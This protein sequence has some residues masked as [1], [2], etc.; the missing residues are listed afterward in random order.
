M[1]DLI[2]QAKTEYYKNRLKL[3]TAKDTFRFVRDLTQMR[4]SCLSSVDSDTAP[5]KKFATFFK[6]KVN[7]IR[8]SLDQAASASNL[9]VDDLLSQPNRTVS[10]W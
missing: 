3:T 10:V 2:K 7:S 1:V 8:D 4:Q 6:H 9:P 5:D